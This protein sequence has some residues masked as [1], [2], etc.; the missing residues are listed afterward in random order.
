MYTIATGMKEKNM[1]Q[2]NIQELV[3]WKAYE[4]VQ[5]VILENRKAKATY[6]IMRH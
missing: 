4:E 6:F 2:L 1:R 3:S 5:E